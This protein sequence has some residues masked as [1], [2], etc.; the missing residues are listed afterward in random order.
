MKQFLGSL[1]NK[2]VQTALTIPLKN[3][4]RIYKCRGVMG[5][6]NSIGVKLTAE[7]LATGI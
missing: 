2:N 4:E 1:F 7:S 6:D 5:V 3:I